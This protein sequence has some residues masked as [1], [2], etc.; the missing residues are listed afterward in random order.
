MDCGDLE[1][2]VEHGNGLG[3]MHGVFM[4]SAVINEL[5][6]EDRDDRERSLMDTGIFVY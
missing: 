5:A 1:V 3:V 6:G 4:G 2:R